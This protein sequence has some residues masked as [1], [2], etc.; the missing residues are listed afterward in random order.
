MCKLPSTPSPTPKSA[1]SRT[2]MLALLTVPAAVLILSPANSQSGTQTTE[3]GQ[4]EKVN[5]AVT[6]A[7]AAK[8]AAK[9]AAA[10][11][12]TATDVSDGEAPGTKT[13]TPTTGVPQ[14]D[15]SRFATAAE[16]SAV[17]PSY[18]DI[19]GFMNSHAAID[20][21][22]VKLDYNAMRAGRAA[23]LARILQKLRDVPVSQLNRDD[24]LAYWLNLR[25]LL[26][27][28][29][30]ALE[31]QSSIESE[32][33]TYEY[34]GEMWTTGIIT[35]EGVKLSIDDIERHILL[36]NWPDPDI[37]YGLYQGT[38]GGPA[39]YKPGFNGP[40]VHT[41][42]NKLGQRYINSRKTLSAKGDV[43]KVPAI[44]EWYYGPLFNNDEKKVARHIKAL[45]LPK[46]AK[47]LQK[48]DNVEPV[49]FNYKVESLDKLPKNRGAASR[50]Q[51]SAPPRGQQGGQRR[52]GS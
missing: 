40:T 10:P 51:R 29:S 7:P 12:K 5:N 22:R 14:K 36:A 18:D 15:F 30:I 37:L 20:K 1:K 32:R 8:E 43:L 47:K 48:Y 33:G 11:A 2:R 24:Q 16:I 27:V 9:E 26:V 28:F 49:A 25:N 41:V 6:A 13:D 17:T 19:V 3:T 50:P 35:V 46:M 38:A 34:P 23:G 45:A 21:N 31:G 42:L 39:L 44:Y 52:S 4:A